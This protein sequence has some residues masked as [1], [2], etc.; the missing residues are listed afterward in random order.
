MPKVS[1]DTGTNSVLQRPFSETLCG[2]LGKTLHLEPGALGPKVTFA[3][4]WHFPHRPQHGNFYATRFQDATAVAR[5]I[6]ANYQ[7]LAEQT[8]LWH[9]TWYDSSLPYWLL[10]RLFSTA[11]IL[12]T[13]TCQWWANGRFWAYEGVGCCAGTCA[14]VWNYEHAMARLFPELE[15]SV[16]EMQDFNPRAGFEE[17][18]GTVNFRGESNKLWAGD[19]Q[20][21]TALKA[22]R[23]HQCS[24][25]GD[26]LKRNWPRI[27]KTVEFLIQ[28]DGDERRPDR[29]LAAQYLRHLL[30]RRNTMV[31]SLYLGALRA[32]ESMALEV[33]DAAFAATCRKILDNGRRNTM[34]KLFNGE[35]FIQSVDLKAH[36]EHQYADGCLSDQLFGQG[37]AHQ[38]GLGYLYPVEAVRSALQADLEVQLGTGRGPQNKAHPPQR[39]FARPGEAGLFVCTWP[40][41]KHLGRESVLYRDEVWTGIEYQVAGHMAW[42]GMLTEA[43][44]I[45]RAVHER[46]H[47]AKHNPWNEIECGDHYA[48]AMA[49]YGVFLALCGFEYHGPH[50]HLGFVPR[51]NPHAFKAAFTA[52]EGWG[53]L[54]QRRTDHAQSNRVELRAGRLRL[55]TLAFELPP[56]RHTRREYG[57]SGRKADRRHRQ[58]RLRPSCDHTGQGLDFAARRRAGSEAHVLRGFSKSRTASRRED[59]PGHG[60]DSRSIGDCD[61]APSS[62]PAA[63]CRADLSADSCSRAESSRRAHL[64]GVIAHQA[65]KHEI[66][67]EY[68]GRAIRLNGSAAAFH[69]NLG[70]AYLALRKMPE[71]VACYRRALELKPDF[72]EA[73][74]NLG[75]ALKDQ[76]KLDEAV[77]CY[78]RALE[79][80]PDFAEAH[81]NLGIALKD[82][83]KLDEAV[84]CYR[85][86]LELKPD[87]AE[88][89]NNLGNAL[90]D[91]GKLD[92][93]VACYRRALELKP[94]YAE[95]HNN[96]GNA[97][98]GPGEAGRSGRLLPPGTG[99]EAGLC[100]GAQQPGQCLEGPGKAGRSGRLLPPGPGT[101]AGLCRGTQQPGQRLE[102]PGESGRS[103]RLLPPGIGAEAGLC[104][105]AQQPG[106]CL[107]KDQGKLDEA[108]ACY[109]RALELKPDYAEAHNN[110]GNALKDQG[111]LD[112][113]VACYRRA[114]ELKPD[115]AEAH[116]NL[117]NVLKDQGKLDEAVACYRRALEL[118]PD[119]CGIS[120][121]FGPYAS[122][123][124]LLGRPGGS[125][126]ARDRGR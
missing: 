99:T 118:K 8:R 47:P 19:S 9:N 11:S 84:A 27:R 74:N 10:D 105:G 82:Q 26:F 79:L 62:R 103:D 36:P 23:E 35:Y 45:C 86:A 22:Y 1:K 126:T 73:H 81:N 76:G 110:L 117:G 85:R 125:F 70:G 112:E 53:S 90:K 38:V 92:E 33:G 116:N 72:A 124:V 119:Y 100:R 6:A 104:R 98:E 15:R 102:G 13:G 114:L 29:G 122:T 60:N 50:A 57:S 44:A 34:Q 109:R 18:G 25:S 121:F 7:R 94:D 78:R 91:Q 24:A 108:I 32:A 69:N 30:L 5:Y 55:R 31:G 89:H 93:A 77:A 16:R 43:L 51:L 97:L 58:T 65:G 21:G 37:S 56:V 83:G 49:S 66:A 61:P 111:K 123:S 3:A 54:G 20:G 48:R 75:N 71:A 67:V 42:E 88:A 39:W 87:Y 113:A 106:Q 14:H 63:S 59:K 80:K 68:I 4:V 17:S 40:K 120:W 2:S 115:Y 64:L 52:A 28:Q 95:A 41:S 12:A 107:L 96:L 46:Y 101:E